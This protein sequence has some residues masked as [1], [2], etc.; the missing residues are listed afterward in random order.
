MKSKNI[1][2]ECKN[3]DI[4]STSPG[5]FTIDECTGFDKEDEK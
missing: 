1:C 4:C 5:N 2:D 3:K